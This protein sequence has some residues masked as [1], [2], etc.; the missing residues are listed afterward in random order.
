MGRAESSELINFHYFNAAGVVVERLGFLREEE[1]TKSEAV[2]SE[3]IISGLRVKRN[4]GKK[5]HFWERN[6]LYNK[7]AA[8]KGAVLLKN[9]NSVIICSTRTRMSLFVPWKQK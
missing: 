3:E 1:T 4:T 7:E 9:K 8:F 6:E 5:K 2:S